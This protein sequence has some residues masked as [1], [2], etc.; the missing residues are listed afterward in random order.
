MRYMLAAL[1]IT[2]AINPLAINSVLG[3]SGGAG[4]S[5]QGKACH[6]TGGANKGN[7]GTYDE[8]GACAGSWG[9]TECG[10]NNTGKCADGATKKAGGSGN[11]GTTKP[12]Q[13]VNR[14]AKVQAPAQQTA[15]P[16]QSGAEHRN[17]K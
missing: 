6:V 11:T 3:L 17:R 5:N 2:F 12:G 16:T 1:A 10:G 13:T 7:S 4:S 8:D 9:A 15:Q 14:P